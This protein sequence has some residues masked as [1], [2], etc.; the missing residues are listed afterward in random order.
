MP[1]SLL[2]SLRR[3]AAL[4]LAL[5]LAACAHGSTPQ[6]DRRF[7]DA[8]RLSMAQQVRDPA[9]AGNR[10]PAD[11]LDG[12]SAQAVMQR[13]RASF[14]EPNAQAPQPVQFMLGGGNGK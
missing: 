10:T 6:M 13:Y 3:L 14:A 12:P 8:V 9:G 4:A 7:G 2:T 11:G 5:H 1:N